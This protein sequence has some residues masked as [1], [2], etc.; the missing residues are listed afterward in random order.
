MPDRWQYEVDSRMDIVLAFSLLPF[1]SRG[2]IN[3]FP[4]LHVLSVLPHRASH[5]LTILA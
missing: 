4:R 3:C 1:E 2:H 5:S